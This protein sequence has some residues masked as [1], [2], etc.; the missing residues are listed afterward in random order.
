MPRELLFDD[1]YFGPRWR[2]GLVYRPLVTGK[3][4]VPPGWIIQSNR[5]HPGFNHGTVDFPFE[6]T[7][8]QVKQYELEPL[9]QVVRDTVCCCNH[10]FEE[11]DEGGQACHAQGCFCSKYVFWPEGNTPSAVADRGGEHEPGCECAL[12]MYQGRHYEKG[13]RP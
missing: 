9:D 13:G 5:P 10:W 3:A 11:H 12:C 7:T 8:K 2:Y 6:L 1:T 4:N